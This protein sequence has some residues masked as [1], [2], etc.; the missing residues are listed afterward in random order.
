[1]ANSNE[2]ESLPLPTETRP[3]P[4]FH[5]ASILHVI[6]KRK[7]LIA[8]VWLLIS[9]IGIAI[10]Y[11]LP[12]IYSGETM[13]L[14]APQRIPEHF[15]AATVNADLQQR[16]DTLKQQVLSNERLEKIIEHFHLYRD[17]RSRHVADEILAMMRKDVDL[18]LEKGWSADRP[19]AFRVKFRC[20]DPRV[21][22]EVAD[23]IGQFFIDENLRARQTEAT[24]TS[25]FLDSE[26]QL[27]KRKLES[28]E[29]RLRQ[30]K[31]A[32]T[33]ELPQQ[34]NALL[35]SLSQS[36]MEMAGVQ[37]ALSRAHQNKLV[38]ENSL[39]TAEEAR[40]AREELARREQERA[41]EVAAAADAPGAAPQPTPVER[42]RAELKAL[43]AQF[44]N[45]HP[46]VK[47]AIAEL[48]RLEAEQPA[49]SPSVTRSPD[50]AAARKNDA[51]RM[52]EAIIAERERVAGLRSQVQMVASELDS[53]TADRRRILG[54]IAVLQ[55]RIA[56]LPMREQQLASVTR[57][58]ETSKSN[59]QSLLDKKLGADV[60][61]DMERRRQA[62]QFVM[63]EPARVPSI[64]VRPKRL[65][66][67][68]FAFVFGLVAGLV[69]AFGAEWKSDHLLGAWELPRDTR[70]LAR[71]PQ[72]EA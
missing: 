19:G 67:S 11:R 36:K 71:V 56:K 54:D 38:L 30:F 8:I 26:L 46:D 66:L 63:L 3:R 55:A 40:N 59:Y 50:A 61:A 34:E 31:L 9:T 72:I 62:E 53:L 70:I 13:I 44:S 2:M 48:K 60:A 45:K 5:P 68:A 37:D 24:A 1:M 20:P 18:T 15:V 6:W 35:A 39:A 42:A 14:V 29:A 33:G 32:Y 7:P 57:D 28:Q 58:Y 41:A 22:A 23:Q 27:A 12:A 21:A 4:Q 16:L 47:A 64:P 43:R 17:E 65:L 52:N 51:A 10:I 49:P 25:E 69:S